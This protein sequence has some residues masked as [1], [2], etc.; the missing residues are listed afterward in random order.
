MLQRVSWFNHK[1]RGHPET[2]RG[3]AE[4]DGAYGLECDD[5]ALAREPMMWGSAVT[6]RMPP[7]G[8]QTIM[9]TP[10]LLFL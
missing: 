6:L 8:M 2:Y 4:Y 10:L 5:P 7:T 9:D 1:L 3:P